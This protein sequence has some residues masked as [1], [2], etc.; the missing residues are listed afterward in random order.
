MLGKAK[1]EVDFK[2]HVICSKHWTSGK[3]TSLEDLPT[4][5]FT[6][7]EKEQAQ[8]KPHERAEHWNCAA[9]LCTNSWRTKDKKLLYYRLS[10]IAHSP[11][12]RHAYSKILKNKGVD[13]KRDFICSDHWSTGKRK[14]INE[15]PDLPC[16]NK[17]VEKKTTKK[18]TPL[19][20]IESAKRLIRNQQ[21]GSQDKKRRKLSYTSVVEQNSQ[22]DSLKAEIHDLREQL[23]DKTQQINK[24]CDEVEKLTVMNET[25]ARQ[26]KQFSYAMEKSTFSY[27]CLK[28]QPKKFLYM[29]G[30]STDDFDCLFD[31]IEPYIDAIIYPDC[32]ESANANR[33]LSKK[34]E[35]L[36][37]LAICRHT[38]HLGVM[39][40]MTN[41]S[42]STQSR[43]FTAW[44]VFL[45]T[46]FDTLDLSP[47][48]G[49]IASLLPKDF[50]VSGFQD[51][52]LLG[53]CTENWIASPENY[54]VSNA[55]FSAY[56][57]HDTGK[58]GTTMDYPTWKS[59]NVHRYLSR[60]N[61]R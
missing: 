6:S 61:Y 48:P 40:F 20:K 52:M 4:I 46:L 26:V 13:F 38:M 53:D 29:T 56:K 22:F 49:E 17:Y 58:T 54:D 11:E 9:A 32:R 23:R 24:L 7:T 30:L 19:K 60:I 8:C 18:V 36:C 47:C 37:F 43:I 25:Y 5:K 42:E 41:T 21:S 44:A 34:T 1:N 33:K 55:T 39:A 51:T 50:W 3:R 10:E 59:C 15:L 16:D 31:C 57:N 35:L 2:R 12:K 14:D 45:S 27:D 28:K